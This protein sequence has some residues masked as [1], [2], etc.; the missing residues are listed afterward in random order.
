[1]IVNGV[2]I[3]GRHDTGAEG[4]FVSQDQATELGLPVRPQDGGCNTFSMGNGKLVRSI[5]RVRTWVSFANEPETRTKCWFNVLPKLTS[6]LILGS[7]FLKVTQTLSKYKSRLQACVPILGALPS[8]N[9]IGSTIQAKTRFSCHV[10]GRP[11][12][13]NADS[14]SDL[15]LMSST[16]IKSQRYRLDRRAE[17]RKSVRLADDTVAQTI[18]QVNATVMLADGS[19]YRRT[20]DVLP[21]LTSD[22]LFG[23]EFL[24]EIDAFALHEDSFVEVCVGERYFE[25]NVLTNLG[26]VNDYIRGKISSWI[27]KSSVLSGTACKSYCLVSFYPFSELTPNSNGG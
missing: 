15:D 9:L 20:F 14:A 19:R 2:T 25:L 18:G 21:G 10:D 5:G 7:K 27:T 22:V 11:T 8:V 12:L 1:M 6:G 4:N 26:P 16:Y 23:D 17:V 3:S 24:E 13:V